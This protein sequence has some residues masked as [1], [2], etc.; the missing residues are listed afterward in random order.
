MAALYNLWWVH[1]LLAAGIIIFIY[2]ESGITYNLK[3]FIALIIGFII[4]IFGIISFLSVVTI[5]EFL[6]RRIY[7]AFILLAI[8]G[9]LYLLINYLKLFIDVKVHESE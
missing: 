8:A 1:F 6:M 2:D 5:S 9:Y 7:S 3:F 4:E